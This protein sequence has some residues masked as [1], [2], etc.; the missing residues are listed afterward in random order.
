MIL[1][2]IFPLTKLVFLHKQ[3]PFFCFQFLFWYESVCVK[4]CWFI[5]KVPCFPYLLLELHILSPL[6]Y[7][8]T[9]NQVFEDSI[10]EGGQ[11]FT[12]EKENKHWQSSLTIIIIIINA[13][14]MIPG[15]NSSA[16]CS[17]NLSQCAEKYRKEIF[18]FKPDWAWIFFL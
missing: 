12:S 16:K 8:Q 18:Y 2:F 10:W 17:F 7:P 4:S 6:D 5:S 11:S 15:I 9:S 3:K 14:K 13:R 1:F